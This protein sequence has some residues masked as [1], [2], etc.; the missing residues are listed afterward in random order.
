[1]GL[2]D[3]LLGREERQDSTTQGR[4]Q[5]ATDDERA[6][7]RYRYLLRTAPPDQIERAH[8]EAFATLTPEQRREVLESL[9]AESPEEERGTADDPRS[10][11]RTATRVEI[12]K[13]GT[14][15]R[16]FGGGRGGMGMGGMGLGGVIGGTLLA[17][18]AGAFIGS[19]IAQEMVDDDGDG[20]GDD[21]TGAEESGAGDEQGGE[22]S[23]DGGS[24]AGDE[25][26]FG[27]ADGAGFGGGDFGGGDL[28]G[29]DF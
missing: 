13:P 16:S 17:S 5:R 10:L 29:G 9:A 21:S 22:Q 4:Q 25:T 20:G 26:R 12:R 2:L 3:R 28:G 7:E 24:L 19:A 11:A 8:E 23:S 15:E 18:V 6:V 27:D 14:L 1:M